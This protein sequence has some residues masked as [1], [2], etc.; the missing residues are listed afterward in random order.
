MSAPVVAHT[1]AEFA[2]ARAKLDGSVA[3]VMTIFVKR[4]RASHNPKAARPA[5][6]TPQKVTA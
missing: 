4:V 6:T 1:R 2:D 3:V 5:S